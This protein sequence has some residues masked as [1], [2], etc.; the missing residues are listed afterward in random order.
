M[1]ANAA[2]A[3]GLITIGLIVAAIAVWAV[4][5]YQIIKLFKFMNAQKPEV[6][7]ENM[8]MAVKQ[9]SGE[10]KNAREETE[11]LQ[12]AWDNF[13]NL[14]KKVDELTVGTQEWR[15]A[16]SEANAAALEFAMEYPEL[17]LMGSATRDKNGVYSFD[18]SI[19]NQAIADKKQQETMI[20]AA[21]SASALALKQQ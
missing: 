6:I 19:V 8:A 4:A 17:N 7:A 13:N 5:I 12:S 20:Q 3:A 10:L 9:L 21:Y 18:K 2:F 14:K 16:I 1:T 11:K 15:D